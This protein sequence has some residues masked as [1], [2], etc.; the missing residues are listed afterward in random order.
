MSLD[1]FLKTTKVDI[2]KTEKNVPIFLPPE[3]E[4]TLNDWRDLI[5]VYNR[6][7]RKTKLADYLKQYIRQLNPDYK[8]FDDLLSVEEIVEDNG[9]FRANLKFKNNKAGLT[10]L[11][12]YRAENLRLVPVTSPDGVDGIR[13][14]VLTYIPD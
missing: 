3:Y 8:D 6:T 7:N 5:Q 12:I 9:I 4:I 10:A 2:H 14:V 13:H 1:Q 11:V